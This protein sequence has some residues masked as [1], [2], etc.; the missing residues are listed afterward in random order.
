MNKKHYESIDFLRV[1]LL[2]C[3]II[4]TYTLVS[5]TG[6]PVLPMLSFATC[7][8]FLSYGYFVLRDDE[9]FETRVKRSIRRAAIAFVICMVVYFALVCGS[10]MLSEENVT[11]LF[12]KRY[13]FEFVVMNIWQ[14]YLGGNIWI[15]QALLYSLII[16][17]FLNKWKLLK[18]D[19]LIM[20]VLFVIA[21]LLGE[22]ARLINFHFL[23]YYYIS[24]NFFTRAMPYMLLGRILYRLRSRRVFRKVKRWMWAALFVVGVALAFIEIYGLMSAGYLIYL[25]HMIGFIPMSIGAFMFFLTLKRKF[26]FGKYYDAIG[27][28]GFYLYS[29][30]AQAIYLLLLY[31]FP[32]QIAGVAPYLG[33]LTLVV[34]MLLSVL[35]ARMKVRSKPAETAEK[36]ESEDEASV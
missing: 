6:T 33:I 17:Y 35:Y 5:L 15:I 28:A 7:T 34:T 23:G 1:L 12:T 2:A 16:F 20:V 26:R 8:F 19:V 31:L 13:I 3:V 25:N 4:S 30:V 29:V 14:P 11:V 10:F 21:I 18:Y 27:R 22:A 24:G 9:E 32:N 36:G